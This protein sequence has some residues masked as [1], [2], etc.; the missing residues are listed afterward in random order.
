MDFVHSYLVVDRIITPM[1]VRFVSIQE[2]KL[3]PNSGHKG[4][5]KTAKG[6]CR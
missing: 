6:V 5:I 4:T 3:I 2:T 1:K